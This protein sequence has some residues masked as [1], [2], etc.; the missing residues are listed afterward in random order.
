MLY[1]VLRWL[2]PLRLGNN[3]PNAKVPGLR[4]WLVLILPATGNSAT[5]KLK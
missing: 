4:T 1:K 3:L 2:L 5:S